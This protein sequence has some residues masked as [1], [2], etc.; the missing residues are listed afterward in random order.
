MMTGRELPAGITNTKVARGTYSDT[1]LEAITKSFNDNWSTHS[2]N[3]P[4]NGSFKIDIGNKYEVSDNNI[5]GFIGSVTYSN[6]GNTKNLEKSFYDFSG[7]RY[8]YN[9]SS[10]T[11]L[12]ISVV[13]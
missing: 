9:G 2:V 5:F 8:S 4:I 10:Y 3:A 1:E 6:S 11:E 13:C 12:L 7:A